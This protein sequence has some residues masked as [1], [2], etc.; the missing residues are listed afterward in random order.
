MRAR[1]LAYLDMP[2]DL[3][4]RRIG[5]T[6]SPYRLRWPSG[7][8]LSYLALEPAPLAS[9][10]VGETCKTTAVA[11]GARAP[12]GTDGM[13]LWMRPVCWRRAARTSPWQHE[14]GKRWAKQVLAIIHALSHSRARHQILGDELT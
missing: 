4:H 5:V 6:T 1:L 14:G 9:L 3:C 10:P 11:G 8:S 2:S 12:S 7:G 13:G